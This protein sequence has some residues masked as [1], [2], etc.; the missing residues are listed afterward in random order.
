VESKLYPNRIEF[1]ADRVK[2]E[3]PIIKEVMKNFSINIF[4]FPIIESTNV[5]I[6]SANIDFKL[7]IDKEKDVNENKTS[8]EKNSEEKRSEPGSFGNMPIKLSLDDSEVHFDTFKND[9]E[10]KFI[11]EVSFIKAKGLGIL[12]KWD[13]PDDGDTLGKHNNGLIPTEIM[14]YADVDVT[15]VVAGVPI[16][17]SKFQL[18]VKDIDSSKSP[19]Y[20]TFVGGCNISAAKLSTIGSLKS[21]DE[22]LGDISIFELSDVRLTFNLG[23]TC[24]TASAKQKLLKVI[25]FGSI[26]M[27]LGKFSYVCSLLGMNNEPVSGLMVRSETGPSWKME[28][29]LY[30]INLTIR[31]S[32]EFD[33]FNKFIGVQYSAKFNVALKLWIIKMSSGEIDGEIAIGLRMTSDGSTAFVIRSSPWNIDLTWPKNMADKV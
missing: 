1:E 13:S 20:W 27:K 23:E 32:A 2:T 15:T 16:T 31:G 14:L 19:V 33:A 21:L 26:E 10:I 8:G 30:K 6:S 9:Y 24:L 17:Y 29:N 5:T 3:F 28:Y 11:V 25:D 4:E 7:D 12:L 22:Y 18:G